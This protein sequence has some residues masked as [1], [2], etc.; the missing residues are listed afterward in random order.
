MTVIRVYGTRRIAV[1]TMAI[2][3]TLRRLTACREY[4][5]FGMFMS[6]HTLVGFIPPEPELHSL[7]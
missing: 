7:K 5:F 1:V 4:S 2:C 6:P 3:N